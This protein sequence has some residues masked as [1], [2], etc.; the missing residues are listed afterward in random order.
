MAWKSVILLEPE[1]SC[2]QELSRMREINLQLRRQLERARRDALLYAAS[3]C[4]ENAERCG[5]LTDKLSVDEELFGH[6]GSAY[7]KKLREIA[8]E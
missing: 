5:E 8:G 3:L 1:M 7:A 6:A 2:E 4:E